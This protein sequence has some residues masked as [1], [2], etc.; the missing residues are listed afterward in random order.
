MVK[1]FLSIVM[2]VGGGR[3][4][5]PSLRASDYKAGELPL[6]ALRKERK[7]ERGERRDGRAFLEAY[8]WFFLNMLVYQGA[9]KY[10]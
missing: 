3:N 9:N 5:E 8:L 4:V 7:G 1:V 6:L 2:D 10:L